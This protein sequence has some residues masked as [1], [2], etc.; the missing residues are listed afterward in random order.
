[1]A[2]KLNLSISRP[3]TA[4]EYNS[5][6]LDSFKYSQLRLVLHACMWT[7]AEVILQCLHFTPQFKMSHSLLQFFTGL[8]K[9]S[10]S[11][12]GEYYWVHCIYAHG[13]TNAHPQDYTELPREIY[14]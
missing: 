12:D 7:H 8:Y 5:F 11:K 6:P 4:K 2:K 10:Y 14:G 1:M 3:E 13:A 9:V